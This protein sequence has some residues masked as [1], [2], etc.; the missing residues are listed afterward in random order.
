LGHLRTALLE[1]SSNPIV[2]V[3][4]ADGLVVEMN[5]AV[6]ATTGFSRDELIGRADRELVIPVSSASPAAVLSTLH[7]L[8]S[9][10]DI[11][12][13]FRTRSGELRA[14]HLSAQVI[15]VEGQLDALCTIR[16]SRDPTPAE[17]RI[18]AREELVRI[19]T[20]TTSPDAATAALQAIGEC[21]RWEL[22][23]FWHVDPA[24]ERLACAAVWHSPLVDM[25]GLEASRRRTNFS[26]DLG[27]PG[28]I[29]R[30]GQAAWITDVAA[31]FPN[32]RTADGHVVHGWFG[33]PVV[34]GD[35]VLGVVEFFSRELRQPDTEL[36]QMT[37]EF[38]RLFGRL[39]RGAGEEAEAEQAPSQAAPARP[40]TTQQRLLSE[41]VAGVAKLHELLQAVIKANRGDPDPA[42]PVAGSN[43]SATAAPRNRSS[44][45]LTLKALSDL[46]GVPAGTLRTWERRYGFTH[47]SRSATG[48]RQYGEADV[49]AP[50]RSSACGSRV[51]GSARRCRPSPEGSATRRTPTR[52]RSTTSIRTPTPKAVP[53]LR[54][55]GRPPRTR[56]GAPWQ[57]GSPN[58][59]PGGTLNRRQ[60]LAC[61]RLCSCCR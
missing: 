13:G 5:E 32:G 17:R 18:A 41:L 15:E 19:L 36:L 27:L 6:F 9:I 52:R 58:G 31:E 1:R 25:D 45:A 46:T 60:R 29:W 57:Q 24:A 22:G 10:A 2:V 61:Y 40:M 11:P 3:R 33:F 39:L 44:G 30:A 50:S 54:R 59:R 26:P 7:A 8:G 48:Y 28:R 37:T 53:L 23:T 49:L 4:L 56:A 20:A 55:R 34:A 42:A 43:R 12:A 51:Y 16:D 35:D 21:L 14:G 38:G 47:P